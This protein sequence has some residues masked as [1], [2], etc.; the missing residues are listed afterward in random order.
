[1]SRFD[2]ISQD[3]ILSSVNHVADF[4]PK[5][6]RQWLALWCVLADGGMLAA[7]KGHSQSREG[8]QASAPS[9]AQGWEL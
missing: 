2:F 3:Q 9:S 5:D 7:P 4:F 1:M 6:L 8:R